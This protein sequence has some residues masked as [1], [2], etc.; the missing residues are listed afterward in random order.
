MLGFEERVFGGGEPTVLTGMETS[1]VM[2][3]GL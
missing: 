2:A 3:C 1:Q